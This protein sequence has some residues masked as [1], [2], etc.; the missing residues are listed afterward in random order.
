MNQA[1]YERLVETA[2]NRTY[3]TYTDVAPLVSLDMEIAG[4]RDRM[5][6]LLE[7][8]ARFEEDNKRPMLTAVVIHRHDNIPGEGFFKIA[9]D[10]GRFDGRDKLRFWIDALNEVHKHWAKPQK[11]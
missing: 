3:T 6:L 8:I 4:D 5:S 11:R 10:F 7:E 1:L 9:K 2:R